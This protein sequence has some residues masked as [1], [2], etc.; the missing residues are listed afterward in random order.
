MTKDLLD[1]EILEFQTIKWLR[2]VMK[3]HKEFQCRCLKTFTNFD[4]W[5]N[6][7]WI[8]KHIMLTEQEVQSIKE[9]AAKLEQ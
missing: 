1:G 5:F 4:E 7:I 6:H 3:N 9:F 2:Q 8:N